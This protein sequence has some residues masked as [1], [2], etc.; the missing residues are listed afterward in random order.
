CG[1]RTEP[2]SEPSICWLL[3]RMILSLLH[4][5]RINRRNAR[6]S[7]GASLS[8]G[9]EHLYL[10]PAEE[11]GGSF[12]PVPQAPS[13]G[14]RPFGYYLWRA[15]LW[16]LGCTGTPDRIP[17]LTLIAGSSGSR[18]DAAHPRHWMNPDARR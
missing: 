9:H 18:F 5:R 11:A 8:A 10:H 3:C 13:R 15:A 4:A 17:I 12:A 7:N 2:W 16:R 6:D 14:G 1:K